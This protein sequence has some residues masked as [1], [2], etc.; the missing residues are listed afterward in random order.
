VRRPSWPYVRIW[1]T[2]GGPAGKRLA[3]FIAKI[4]EVLERTG[5]L[6]VS[7]EARRGSFPSPRQRSMGHL[8][9]NGEDSR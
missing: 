8:P 5:E 4:V 2:L 3:P 6:E 9:P 7:P 1:A